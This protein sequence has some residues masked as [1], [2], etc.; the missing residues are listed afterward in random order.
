MGGARLTRVLRAGALVVLVA[1]LAFSVRSQWGDV[2]HD[3]GRVSAPSAVLA[4]ALS[5]LAVGASCLAWR[6]MLADLG[7]RLRVV[8]AAHV[9]SVSQLGKY[10]PGSVWPVVAQ[11][12]LGRAFH[13]P[14]L[15]TATA[16]FLTLLSSLVVAV[17]IGGL[18][19]FSSPGWGRALALLPVVLL[20]LHPRVLTPLS[21]LLARLLRR[22]AVTEPPTLGGVARTAAWI[23]VQWVCLGLGTAVLAADLGEH[24]PVARITGAVALSWAAGLVVVV[25]PAGA[26]IREGALTLLLAPVMGSAS[27]LAVAL[28]GR[29]ALT[30]AD[31]V[32]AVVG[33]VLARRART[34]A[35]GDLPVAVAGG[36]DPTQPG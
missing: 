8:S 3:L 18:L 23:A 7:S 31:A 14:R 17:A 36:D 20:V 35:A 2:R 33:L 26:G 10:L 12:E 32:F 21:G 25:V 6:S 16:F 22:P 5:M 13:V 34:H 15:R 4:L 29:L 9:F 19:A 24:A 28:L 11:M 30:I 1:A 27:A